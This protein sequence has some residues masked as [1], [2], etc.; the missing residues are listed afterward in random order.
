MNANR[1]RDVLANRSVLGPEAFDPVPNVES[2]LDGMAHQRAE[3]TP[4]LLSDLLLKGRTHL[5]RVDGHAVLC[6]ER[7][8][9]QHREARE[10]ERAR[11]HGQQPRSIDSGHDQ[12]VRARDATG[13]DPG[14]NLRRRRP[15][16]G[17]LEML[18][19]RRWRRRQLPAL[20]DAAHLRHKVANQSKP[21]RRRGRRP[22]GQGVGNG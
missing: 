12:H 7:L 10:R 1:D 9:L 8:R 19:V 17:Q 20:Q 16:P 6:G 5:E 4:P 22:G 13:L 21:P 11:D 2:P 3:S 18:H 14:S 15:R